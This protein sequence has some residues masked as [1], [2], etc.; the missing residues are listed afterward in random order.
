MVG[1]Y[2]DIPGARMAYDVDG[3]LGFNINSAGTSIVAVSGANMRALNKTAPGDVITVTTNGYLSLIF[4]ENRDIVAVMRS[5][6]GNCIVQTSTNTTNGFDGTWTQLLA[7]GNAGTSPEV[8]YRTGITTASVS[9][10][11]AIRFQASTGTNWG[12]RGLHIY[13]QPSASGDRLEFWHPTLDQA[14]RVTPAHLDYGDHPRSSSTDKSFRV[15][16]LSATLTA[17]SITLGTDAV[18]D[19][20]PTKLSELTM[21]YN[22]GAFGA[23]ASIASL[24][25]GA[26]SEVA[27]LRYAPGSGSSLGLW[28][29]RLTAVASSWT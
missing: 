15:K 24:A 11:K 12:A 21:N 9:N 26:I 13:G 4:P 5:G 14:L 22:G 8:V 3:T 7:G 29:Q 19:T 17:G 1:L 20:A 28:Q 2:P 18:T 6:S 10:I 16:N 23:T 25:P 27:N